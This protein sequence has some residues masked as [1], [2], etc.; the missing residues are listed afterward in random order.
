MG[1]G[2]LEGTALS[3]DVELYLCFE[4]KRA[5]KKSC[6][7]SDEQL[8][9]MVSLCDTNFKQEELST[10]ALW[11]LGLSATKVRELLPDLDHHRIR[12]LAAQY[13]LREMGRKQ[14]ARNRI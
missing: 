1:R 14:T 12:L 4:D 13:S 8:R 10:Y 11:C 5:G 2:R 3:I 6:D 7:V 9:D